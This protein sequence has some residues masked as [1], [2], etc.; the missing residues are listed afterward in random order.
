M[1]YY[2]ALQALTNDGSSL[3][4]PYY[5]MYVSY[6]KY[7]IKYQKANGK[8]NRNADSDYIDYI[9][10]INKLV[11]QEITGQSVNFVPV[12]GYGGGLSTGFDGYGMR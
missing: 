9:A 7:R 10:R 5:D 12:A 2:Q 11:A 8:I 1:D 3:D 6:L 4:E